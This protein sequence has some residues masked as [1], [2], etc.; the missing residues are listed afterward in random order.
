MQHP[1]QQRI[2]AVADRARAFTIGYGVAWVVFWFLASLTVVT[3]LDYLF[4]FRDH[5]VRTIALMAWVACVLWATK[6]YLLPAIVLDWSML[7]IA[8]RIEKR[9]PHLHDQL[10][11]SID[12]IEN[13]ELE[14]TAGSIAMRRAVIID[15]EARVVQLPLH[16]VVDMSPLRIAIGMVIG[17]GLLVSIIVWRAPESAW[18]ACKRLSMPWSDEAWHELK[19]LTAPQRVGKGDE[20]NL[21]VVDRNGHLPKR[22]DLE[23]WPDDQPAEGIVVHKMSR[24][25]A[26]MV[27]LLPNVKEPLRYRAVGGDHR[28]MPWIRLE[29][30]APPK[31][32]SVDV[33]LHPPEYMGIP[34]YPAERPMNLWV[35]TGIAIDGR[36]TRPLRA[37]KLMVDTSVDSYEYPLSITSELDQFVTASTDDIR[38]N[39]TVCKITRS[40]E[41]W[42]ELV[43]QM[44]LRGGRDQ[45]WK[46]QTVDHHPPT[47]TL[48]ESGRYL[49][50]TS[51][52]IVPI[53]GKVTDQLA[54]KSIGIR[55]SRSDQA[56]QGSQVVSLF[57]GPDQADTGRIIEPS[58]AVFDERS[59]EF[60]WDLSTLEKLDPGVQIVMHVTAS[61]YKPL[62]NQSAPQRLTILSLEEFQ[63]RVTHHQHD[64]LGQ[65]NQ[66]LE[67]QHQSRIQTKFFRRQLHK[68]QHLRKQNAD[69]VQG[70]ELNQREILRLLTSP[71]DGI[72]VQVEQLLGVL[73]RNRPGSREV[74]I[75]MTGI[76]EGIQGL[77]ERQL[78]AI[79]SNLI[80]A[81]KN[82]RNAVSPTTA[83]EDTAQ[84]TAISNLQTSLVSAVAYQDK[85]IVILEQML[86]EMTTWDDFRRLGQDVTKLGEDQAALSEDTK[87][88]GKQTIGK[89]TSELTGSE[90]VELDELAV[91]QAELARRL[92]KLLVQIENRQGGQV[93][94]DLTVSSVLKDAVEFAKRQQIQDLMRRS[95][96]NIRKNQ[97]SHSNLN[98]KQAVKHL[99]QLQNVLS[100]GSEHAAGNPEILQLTAVLAK[101]RERQTTI[102]QRTR[103][104]EESRQKQ[105]LVPENQLVDLVDQQQK[106]QLDIEV[107]MDRLIFS[108]V[109]RVAL[110]RVSRDMQLALEGLRER[111][112]TGPATQK[113]ELRAIDK[114]DGLLSALGD[115]SQP[116]QNEQSQ[117]THSGREHEKTRTDSFPLSITE[118]KL[119]RQMQKEINQLT[120]DLEK[121]R[122][123]QG[124]LSF[125]KQKELADLADDQGR[126]AELLELKMEIED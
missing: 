107:F 42:F 15:T 92:G 83:T 104:L 126:L 35:G 39:D 6:R 89:T 111:Q 16:Q 76:L 87:A 57:R 70:V 81:L 66:V 72:Q 41:F 51:N 9:F 22:V 59:I 48:Q 50:V 14:S 47:I 43:D 64:I 32:T 122:N 125:E 18:L 61:N 60:G 20:L 10:S 99:K 54:V 97:I 121:S 102:Y 86:G 109:I 68:V 79:R 85:V 96:E 34:E 73:E 13:S 4:A 44:G 38:S 7:E 58:G 46:I 82:A 27:C 24:E 115:E 114:M 103:Q 98:Q 23:I 2:L 49:Y 113:S 119:L 40:G 17:I 117:S 78:P 123:E 101:C 19:F 36:A 56:D 52:A 11:T 88:I 90:E 63:D 69:Q 124:G 106:L 62:E 65:L 77:R 100:I 37:A 45:C 95:G 116:I 53:R 31:I 74:E 5:G 29:V 28:T 108:K 30:I 8:G 84:S 105:D 55:F 3:S 67:K 75:R 91:R 118:L 71:K 93:A 1:L 110:D 80:A 33:T 21:Q 94:D 25:D 120:A 26:M 12:F 112:D